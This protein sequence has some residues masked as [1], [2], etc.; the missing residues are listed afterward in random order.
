[1]SFHSKYTIKEF[2]ELKRAEYAVEAFIQ[3]D[4]VSV[5]HQFENRKDIE[6]AAFFT[7]IF[8]WGKRAMIIR[9]ADVLMQMMEY[10]PY[11]FISEHGTSDL[12]P[13]LT[14]QYRTFMGTDCLYFIKALQHLY[15]EYNSMEDLFQG[16]EDMK[17][18]ILHF[19]NYFL[20]F[21]HKKRTEKHIANP[22]ANASAKRINLFLRWMVRQDIHG[23]D[24]G[25][26]EKICP[27]KLYCPL[28]VHSGNV[29][30]KL[31]LLKRKSNDWKACV[32]LTEVLREFDPH[33]PVKYDIAL[34]GLGVFENF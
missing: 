23:I 21:P 28:D 20:S 2:L 10:Q 1:M 32:A 17:D 11:K 3:G 5:P 7:A 29:A 22:S 6:I 19:R 16:K 30:R 14:F 18:G 27:S 25:L 34:F 31:G 8:S 13:F 9:S 15:A 24:F 33:D 12:K 4:P 26:W